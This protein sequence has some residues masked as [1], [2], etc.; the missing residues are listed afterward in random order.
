MPIAMNIVR[1]K[2]KPGQKDAVIK[3]HAEIDISTWPGC[4]SMRMIDAGDV[5]CGFGEWESMEHMQKAMP[6]MIALLDSFRD[7]LDEISS[8]LGVTDPIRGDV[9]VDNK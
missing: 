5:L 9:V 8:E 3:A 6:Q 4:I 7:H 1:F 2:P